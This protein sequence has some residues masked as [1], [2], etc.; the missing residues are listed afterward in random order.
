MPVC[1]C[2]SSGENFAA[3]ARTI[4]NTVVTAIGL[5]SAPSTPKRPAS[6]GLSAPS[7][8]VLRKWP[9][10]PGIGVAALVTSFQQ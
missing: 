4:S 1:F 7:R 10:V 5:P 9:C 3:S 2:V 6:A 8:S